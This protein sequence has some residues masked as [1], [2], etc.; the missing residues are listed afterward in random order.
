M[1]E[2]ISLNGEWDWA[3]PGGPLEPKL[4]P[5]SYRCVGEAT[6]SRTFDAPLLSGRRFFLCFAGIT[7]EGCVRVNGHD[8]G[9]MGPFTPYEFDIT[10]YMA[11]GANLLE[12]NVKDI[13]ASYGP[14]IGW[15]SYAGLIREVYLEVG[16]A[17]YIA[18]YHWQT[19]LR[20]GYHLAQCTLDVVIES[21]CAVGEGVLEAV[22]AYHGRRSR[23]STM[24]SR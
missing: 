20:D 23:P 11:P 18:D 14:L 5:T 19:D 9:Q 17:S 2:R 8:V 7:Y 24:P 3:I 16:S 4:V 13:L 15:E 12:V 6:Y 1:R 10:P 21:A 22:L